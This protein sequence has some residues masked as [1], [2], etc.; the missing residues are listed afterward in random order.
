VGWQERKE[1][2]PTGA[3]AQ[4]EECYK[5]QKKRK[6]T[7]GPSEKEMTRKFFNLKKKKGN[8]ETSAFKLEC[9]KRGCVQK[10]KNRQ[11]NKG[12]P[13]SNGKPSCKNW[14]LVVKPVKNL[15]PVKKK[16]R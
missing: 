15:R 8:K 2:G 6:V 12:P 10:K 14:D 16:K 11:P 7:K 5:R 1:D 3:A 13:K 9:M 4:P